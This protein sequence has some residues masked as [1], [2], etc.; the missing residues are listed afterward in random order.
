[1]RSYELPGVPGRPVSIALR[2]AAK[3]I[4][5]RGHRAGNPG[6]PSRAPSKLL[7][8]PHRPAPSIPPRRRD[9]AQRG[10]PPW[11][12]Q[13]STRCCQRVVEGIPCHS[14]AI[15]LLAAARS[16]HSVHIRHPSPL[17]RCS[18]RPETMLRDQ[19]F[20]YA[21][22]LAGAGRESRLP[23]DRVQQP[24]AIDFAPWEVRG[25]KNLGYEPSKSDRS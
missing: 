7:R 25:L 16:R 14:V 23:P 13:A 4:G 22:G 19:S 15:S 3:E 17:E 21:S 12:T 5:F 9:G 1:M 20:G 24:A 8:A 6:Q 18:L 2:T 10:N 11:R